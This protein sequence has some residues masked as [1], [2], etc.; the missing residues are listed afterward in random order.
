MTGAEAG[1]LSLYAK[2]GGQLSIR[3]VVDDLYQ[4]VLA[5]ADLA[6]YFRHV[7][8]GMLRRHQYELLA[9]VTGGPVQ[10]T[11]QE[12]AVAHAGRGISATH[13]D[14]LMG[15]LVAAFRTAGADASAISAVQAVLRTFRA[16]IVAG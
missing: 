11:G 1:Q 16:E 3:K 2:L 6:S 4:R 10:Y 5:D 7:D 8:M 15:H 9:T 13:Y 14:L 12:M